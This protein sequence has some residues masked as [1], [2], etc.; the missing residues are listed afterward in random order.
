MGLS[1]EAS[2]KTAVKIISILA[3]ITIAE[4]AFALLGKGYII[5][6]LHFPV[7]IMGLVMIAM[8]VLKAYLIIYEFMHMKYE[9]P[10]MVKS[11]ML[12][13]FLL[14]W[15]IIAFLWEGSDWNHRRTLIKEKNE[16]KATQDALE[17]GMIYHI[18]TEE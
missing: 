10:G 17:T 16:L 14:V 5:D 3:V 4:V 6:G 11:V 13:T 9:V 12:P 7:A 18:P 8:S 1:Y 2:K 15:A